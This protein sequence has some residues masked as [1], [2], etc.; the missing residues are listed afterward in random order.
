MKNSGQT[1][2]Y[3]R[4]LDSV[5]LAYQQC[6]QPFHDGR[7]DRSALP[8][9]AEQLMRSRYSA[10]VLGLAPYLLATWHESTRPKELELDPQM[11]WM[12][13]EIITT[14]SGGAEANRGVVEFAAHY[15]EGPGEAQQHEV[16]TFVRENGAWYYLDAL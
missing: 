13:L 15:L 10:F 3:C 16:S 2:C 1:P 5:K 9:T 6:C 4:E 12:G 11:R 7:A 14:R 8:E